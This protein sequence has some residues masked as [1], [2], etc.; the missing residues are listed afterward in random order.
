MSLDSSMRDRRIEMK[1]IAMFMAAVA[2]GAV[3]ASPYDQPYSL[4]ESGDSSE[5]RKEAPASVNKVD[6]SEEP[7]LNSSHGGISRMPSS[8]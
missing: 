8:A 5:V 3:A 6:R 2:V 4:A 1:T 7:R